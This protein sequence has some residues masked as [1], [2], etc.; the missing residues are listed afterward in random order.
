M[1]RTVHHLRSDRGRRLQA[2]EPKDRRGRGKSMERRKPTPVLCINPPNGQLLLAAHVFARFNKMMLPKYLK[3]P[4]HSGARAR[5]PP[6]RRYPSPTRSQNSKA[7][8]GSS[9]NS[10]RET[11]SIANAILKLQSTHGLEHELPPRDAI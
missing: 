1:G 11:L 9:T 7:L 8:G 3:T 5:T 6:E 2:E 4:K 10:P